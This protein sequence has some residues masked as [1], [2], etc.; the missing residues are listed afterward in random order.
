MGVGY[1]LN[2]YAGDGGPIEATGGG[3][4]QRVMVRREQETVGMIEI[5]GELTFAVACQLMAA[6][7]RQEAEHGE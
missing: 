3:L 4:G 2:A 6:G 5:D 7:T 1:F